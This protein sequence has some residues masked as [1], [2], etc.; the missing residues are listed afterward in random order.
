MIRKMNKEKRYGKKNHKKKEKA[1]HEEMRK[2]YDENNEKEKIK[3]MIMMK[4]D[5]II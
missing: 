3:I 4:I 1:V 2:I 5:E